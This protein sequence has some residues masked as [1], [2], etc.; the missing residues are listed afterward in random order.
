MDEKII[1]VTEKHS[2]LLR[3][4]HW[5]N[6]PLLILMIWSGTLIYWA[7]QAYIKIP[8][9]L[10]NKLGIEFRLAMGM[11]W[12]FFL[13]WLFALNGLLYVI[14]LFYSGEWRM[15]IPQKKSFKEAILVVLHDLKIRST[16]PAIEGKFNAAQRIA[17]TGVIIMGAGALVTGLAIYKPVQAGFLT[18]VL[19]GYEAARLEHFLLTI[20][21]IL[22]IIVHVLQV[23]KAGWNNFRAMIAGYEIEKE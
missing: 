14:Y 15:L 8:D 10:A 22:F 7:N 20:G 1:S 23:I 2:G 18:A 19:G 12:H 11:G 16:A 13:M 17:Y 5:I 3:I 21:F 6:F 9:S 4:F